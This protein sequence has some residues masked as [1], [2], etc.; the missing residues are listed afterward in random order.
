MVLSDEPGI[1]FIPYLLEQAFNDE[2]IS[3]Y[4]VVDKIKQYYDFGGVRIEDDILI[5]EDGCVNL[6]EG[7]PR[8]TT[9]IEKAMTES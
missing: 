6:T 3:K 5:T 2:K 9:D 8:T 4:F 1:Y 7:L